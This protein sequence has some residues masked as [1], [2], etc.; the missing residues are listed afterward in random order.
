MKFRKFTDE[1]GR[2][3]HGYHHCAHGRDDFDETVINIERSMV[4]YCKTKSIDFGRCNKF[5]L[6]RKMGCYREY[7]YAL[8]PKKNPN[9]S[10]KIDFR[11]GF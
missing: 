8:A 4:R 3:S 7:A 5:E 2:R 6:A 11:K 10:A 9:S 1:F